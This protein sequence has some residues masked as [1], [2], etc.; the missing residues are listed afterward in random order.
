LEQKV[1]ERTK[2]LEEA[3][4]QLI[5]AEKQASL[6]RMVAG[7]AHE[8][9]T[10]IGVALTASS[11]LNT[12]SIKNKKL[13]TNSELTEKQFIDSLD[14][15]ITSTEIINNNIYRAAGLIKSFKEM[16]VDT[17]SQVDRKIN[18]IE[19]TDVVLMTL[20]P[21][22]K[23][24]EIK[25]ESDIENYDI[26]I[27]PSHYAQL[28]TNF[29]TNSIDHGFENINKGTIKLKIY[30]QKG[31]F[32]IIYENDGHKI[33]QEDIDNIFDPFYTTKRSNGFTGIGLNIV[34]NIVRDYFGGEIK[35]ENLD[36]GIRF[37]I[38]FEPKFEYTKVG[39]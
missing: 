15:N 14:E 29:I 4:G 13:Y 3:S 38:V 7:I 27:N 6:G 21:K 12:K 24:T 11:F 8:I 34:Y 33:N 9:N 23:H 32:H 31:K 16:S 5:I 1:I 17:T 18:L 20:H 22:L 26:I 28:L 36:K 19:Y 2:Q 25:F 30:F 39:D 10:P 37:T 35:V